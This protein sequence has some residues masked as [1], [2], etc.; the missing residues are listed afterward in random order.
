M[1]LYN[2]FRYKNLDKGIKN[3][4]FCDF[5]ELLYYLTYV[6]LNCPKKP[7]CGKTFV[8]FYKQLLGISK[9]LNFYNF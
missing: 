5:H 3:E 4:I 7:Q 6:L 8:M 9:T 1:L 2:E